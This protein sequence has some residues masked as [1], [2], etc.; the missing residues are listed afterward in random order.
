MTRKSIAPGALGAIALLAGCN[1]PSRVANTS[2]MVGAFAGPTE[3][4]NQ[5]SGAVGGVTAKGEV[6]DTDEGVTGWAHA[7]LMLGGNVTGWAG[8]LTLEGELGYAGEIGDDHYLFARGGL[9]GTVERDPY[10]GLYAIEVPTATIGYQ[11]HGSGTSSFTDSMHFDIGLHGGLFA[12]GRAFAKDDEL[13]R[14]AD[15]EV[16][17]LAVL[18]GEFVKV[19]LGHVA[20]FSDDV[21]H[22]IR[23]SSCLGVFI[24]ICI[25]TRHVLGT[26]PLATGT[27]YIETH[28]VGVSMGVGLTTGLDRY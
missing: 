3:I 4:S 25:D 15:P 2:W 5:D 26:W 9:A 6:A 10:T 18:M 8:Q 20:V 22:I 17:P 24:A 11:F 28:F 14:V 27:R 23:S 1:T 12:A 13:D 7:D 19:R 21:T 16:G